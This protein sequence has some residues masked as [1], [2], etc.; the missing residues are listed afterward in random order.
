MD[1]SSLYLVSTPPQTDIKPWRSRLNSSECYS[2]LPQKLQV[3]ML[4]SPSDAKLVEAVVD[5]ML[6][7]LPPMDDSSN[8]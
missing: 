6:T 7:M 3:L 2:A 5:V 4:R 8:S 1:R